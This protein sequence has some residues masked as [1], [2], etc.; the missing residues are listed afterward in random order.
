MHP[1]IGPPG[2]R[3]PGRHLE[4]S[5][6]RLLHHPLHGPQPALP[7]PPMEIRP[8]VREKQPNDPHG[9]WPRL[10]LGDSASAAL[11]VSLRENAPVTPRFTAPARRTARRFSALLLAPLDQLDARHRS[12]VALALPQLQDPGVA[13]ASL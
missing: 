3:Q 11:A 9:S 8:V 4:H 10:R 6:E 1:R 13:A 2:H 5:S 12:A 7:R